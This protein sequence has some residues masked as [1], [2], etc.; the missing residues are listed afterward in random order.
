MNWTPLHLHTHY[1]LLDGLSKPEQ[2]AARCS[3]LGYDSCAV[4]DHG[5]IAGAVSFTK[6]MKDKGIKPILG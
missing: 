3:E 6:A 1:S 5:T 4:T 2:V